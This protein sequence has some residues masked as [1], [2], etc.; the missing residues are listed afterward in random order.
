MIGL[1]VVVMSNDKPT[2]DESNKGNFCTLKDTFWKDLEEGKVNVFATDMYSKVKG[3][4]RSR[5][6]KKQKGEKMHTLTGEDESKCKRRKL[7]MDS[8]PTKST[9]NQKPMKKDK[10]PGKKKKQNRGSK[11]T[12]MKE[13]CTEDG[14][15]GHDESS[16]HTFSSIDSHISTD[17][18]T[19]LG[20]H[21]KSLSYVTSS[22]EGT[23]FSDASVWPLSDASESVVSS[24]QGEVRVLSQSELLV[25]SSQECDS[26]K[27]VRVNVV[28]SCPA[29][30]KFMKFYFL[31]LLKFLENFEIKGKS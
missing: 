12:K 1:P 8:D 7:D 24:S 28:M 20:S 27:Q 9:K 31:V 10:K 14:I 3:E 17:L 4:G 13:S 2:C 29:A 11:C 5:S 15:L 26:T 6:G 19:M 22:Q 25:S 16:N 30:L 18:G 21:E 23:S